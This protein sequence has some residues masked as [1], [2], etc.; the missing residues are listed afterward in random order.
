MC[1]L[2]P[3]KVIGITGFKLKIANMKYSRGLILVISSMLLLG[4][5]MGQVIEGTYAI[6]NLETGKLL[7]PKD[8][9]KA[10]GAPIVMYSPTNWKCLTW[11]FKHVES[12]VYQ[13][14]NL[15]SGKTF[16]SEEPAVKEGVLLDQAPLKTGDKRQSWEFISLK[17]N[18]FLI[19]LMGTDY[20]LTPVDE[21]GATNSRVALKK[22]MDGNLQR[23]TI[24]EQDPS[25]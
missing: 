25:L 16:Q 5:L 14:E 13:L 8:A 2:S 23:W 22:K 4:P 19:R 11:D 18:T 20:Y 3:C 10:D 6:K 9:S 21:K 12:D 7:R 1:C 15:F 17:E 24:Y